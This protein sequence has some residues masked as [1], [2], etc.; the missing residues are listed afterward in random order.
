MATNSMSPSLYQAPMGIDAGLGE[1][2]LEIEIENPEG[3][4]ITAGGM[5]IE[6]LPKKWMTANCKS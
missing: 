2:D 4:T 1:P 5:E 3:V 6:I